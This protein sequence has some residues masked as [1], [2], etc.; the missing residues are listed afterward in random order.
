[1]IRHLLV[2]LSICIATSIAWG[3]GSAV[4]SAASGNN[5]PVAGNIPL[6]TS[7]KVA[8]IDSRNFGEGIGEMKK[9]LDRLDAEFQPRTKE[10]EGLQ[11]QLLKLEE[12]IKVGG[13]GMKPEILRQKT[14]QM[15]GLKKDFERKRED[16]QADLQKRYELVL[17]PIQE[18]LRKFLESYASSREIVV[19]LDLAPAAQAGLLFLNPGIN[20]TE[21]F[22][23]EYN[24]QNPV[25]GAAPQP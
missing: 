4:K 18:K 12:E 17:G 2:V 14:D 6:L 13:G 20:I 8:V 11:A 25:A 24:K 5:K 23:K 21:E 22:I 1:M 16:Y 3:Q 10:L 19:V 9:Q 7:G 15:A